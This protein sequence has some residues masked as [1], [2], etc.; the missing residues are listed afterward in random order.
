MMIAVCIFSAFSCSPGWP[1]IHY[2]PE[3]D[4]DPLIPPTHLPSSEIYCLASQPALLV[5]RGL[6]PLEDQLKAS[7][8]FSHCMGPGDQLIHL[9]WWQAPFTHGAILPALLCVLKFLKIETRT[10]WYCEF[11][12]LIWFVITDLLGIL[13][14]AAL[15]CFCFIL[16]EELVLDSL[17]ALP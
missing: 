15:P 16:R 6:W 8:L 1:Q 10:F 7:I 12:N 4:L 2:V 13:L 17:L 9:A 14:S 11:W 5:C 3:A